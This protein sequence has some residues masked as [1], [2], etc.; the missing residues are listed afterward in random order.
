[1]K[2]AAIGETSADL[3]IVLIVDDDPH[4]INALARDL[5]HADCRLLTATGA[6]QGLAILEQQEVQVVLADYRMPE[7]QGDELLAR[8]RDE[9]PRVRRI[10]L[11]GYSSLEE[12]GDWIWRGV[13]EH[14]VIKPWD[15]DELLAVIMN[16]LARQK[17][18]C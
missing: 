1:M 17:E 10:M 9:F 6:R 18:R 16:C 12:G 15:R 14:L 13:A 2:K 8:V 3:P 7:M 4:I 11:S 5:R